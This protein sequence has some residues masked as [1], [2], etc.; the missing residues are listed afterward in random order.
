[1]RAAAWSA[2]SRAV[3]F[4]SG[5]VGTGTKIAILAVVNAIGVWAL[6][7]LA[8]R[9]QW[10]AAAA[11]LLVTAIIDVIYMLPRAYPAKFLLPGTFFLVAFQVI[12]ILYTVNVALTNYSTG[13][14]V[15]KAAA[16][17]QIEQVTLAE[18][19]SG[20]TFTMTPADDSKG[21]LVLLL[22]DDTNG[23][24]FVGTKDELK[25]VPKGTFT[26]SNGSITK[27]DGYKVL[28]GQAL[29]D[30]S[31]NLGKL[32]VPSGGQ[33]GIRAEG[34]STAVELH[35]TL[36]YDQE[37]DVF[38]RISDGTVFRD[39]G[40]GSFVGAK[41]EQLLPGWKVNV[42]LH[43]FSRLIH[44]RA[45]RQ[46]FLRVFVWNIAYA[47]LTV[48]L[49][50]AIGLFLAITL[51]KPGLR[52]RGAYRSALILPFAIPPFLSLLVWRGLLNDDFGVVNRLLGHIGIHIPWL[53]D[54]N[55]HWYLLHGNWAMVAILIVST[56]LTVP[57]FFLISLGALQAIPA[58]LVEA[59]RVDGGS[60][61]Q[62]FRRVTLPLL[63]VAV[64]PLMIAS[65]AF[66]FND[67]GK[68][69]LLTG[70]GPSV[71]DN[72][73]AGAS[74]ILITYTYKIAFGAGLGQ[75]Y[76]LATAVS[77][78]IFIIVAAISA[79]LFSRTKALENLA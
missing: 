37:R 52:L 65:F 66:N 11:T 55:A 5:P 56:W 20:K 10:V 41:D 67:F 1:M 43:N 50:F 63:L 61:W 53:F 25:E 49:S 19:G 2:P 29:I 70:G 17:K 14:V 31:A 79:F 71:G 42:G 3:A 28:T 73:I 74:D 51:D 62:V 72:T 44:V 76:G 26:V 57:Y 4:F 58:E 15:S 34:L 64:A 9:H 48:L 27:A 6:I 46:P 22:V 7:I 32:I 47:A 77:M 38:V 8:H 59:A 18:T 69:Y 39:N 78:I 60:A 33:N 36:R 35:P 12:P 21:S 45:L 40:R 16:I 23:K 24:T 54:G 13:H 68:V 30:S 75:D